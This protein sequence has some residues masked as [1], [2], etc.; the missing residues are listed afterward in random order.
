MEI[1]TLFEWIFYIGMFSR[2][3]A[4]SFTQRCISVFICM[5]QRF[6]FA[7]FAWVLLCVFA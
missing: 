3:A 7:S 4:K 5:T 2:K 6:F 1:R